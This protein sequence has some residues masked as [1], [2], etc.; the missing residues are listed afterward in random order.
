MKTKVWTVAESCKAMEDMQRMVSRCRAAVEEARDYYILCKRSYSTTPEEMEEVDKEYTKARKDHEAAKYALTFAE[1]IFE[2]CVAYDV[3]RAWEVVRNLPEF[4]E[5]DIG[6]KRSK[7]IA[8][9]ILSEL[10]K[11]DDNYES[12][13]FS[14]HESITVQYKGFGR[15]TCKFAYKMYYSYATLDDMQ[16]WGKT[17]FPEDVMEAGVFFVCALEEKEMRER[18][19]FYW[20]NSVLSELVF[21]EVSF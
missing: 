9:A 8:E 3:Y 12:V 20:K 19:F 2:N 14:I 13:W 11:I 21:R 5:K 16:S 18:E 17:E 4:S 15:V 7:Q 10:K 1:E 6:E